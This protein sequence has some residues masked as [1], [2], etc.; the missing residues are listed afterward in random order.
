MLS[1]NQQKTATAEQ[2]RIHT[3]VLGTSSSREREGQ[4][5]T[6]GR[7]WGKSPLCARLSRSRSPVPER[8]QSPDLAITVTAASAPK[9]VSRGRS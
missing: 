7:E 3:A 2:E 9:E 6:R 5:E 8:L 4:A 1:T